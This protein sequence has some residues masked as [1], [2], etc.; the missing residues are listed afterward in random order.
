M[1][2]TR[3]FQKTDVGGN[4]ELIQ[5]GVSGFIAPATTIPLGRKNS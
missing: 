4:C 2:E 3:F 1:L 5:D